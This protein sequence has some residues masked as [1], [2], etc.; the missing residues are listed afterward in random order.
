VSLDKTSIQ[1]D[2]SRKELAFVEPSSTLLYKIKLATLEDATA[3]RRA[4]NSE[5]ISSTK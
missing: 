3:L 2:R 5:N 4:C 1:S